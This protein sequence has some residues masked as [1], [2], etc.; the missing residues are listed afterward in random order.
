MYKPLLG[1]V[2]AVLLAVG[3]KWRDRFGGSLSWREER[4]NIRVAQQKLGGGET[5]DWIDD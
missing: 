3:A 2:R 4:A 1:I 5:L